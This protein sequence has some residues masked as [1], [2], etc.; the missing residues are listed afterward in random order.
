[1]NAALTDQ[2]LIREFESAD[3]AGVIDLWAKCGL[4]RPWNDPVKDIRRKMKVPLGAFWVGVLDH[5]IIAS[6]MVGYDGHRG[7]VNYL[8][9]DPDF[10]TRGLGR[11]L[12]DRAEVLL[13]EL[14]CPKI[15]LCVRKDNHQ[16]LAFYDELGYAVDDAHVLGKRLISDE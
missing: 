16:V 5:Q 14:G 2:M 6:I 10:A 11:L 9:I 8:A 1:M 12:M 13:R 4:T 15:N 3:M 7:S